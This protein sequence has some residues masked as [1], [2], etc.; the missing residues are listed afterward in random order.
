MAA[1]RLRELPNAPGAVATVIGNLEQEGCH[2]PCSFLAL[3]SR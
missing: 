3:L 2:G 1:E